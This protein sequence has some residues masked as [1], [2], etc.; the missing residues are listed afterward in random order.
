MEVIFIYNRYSAYGGFRSPQGRPQ[1]NNNI[2]RYSGTPEKRLQ[3]GMNRLGR[4]LELF[5]MQN[6]DS[7]DLSLAA[8][9]FLLYLESHDEDFLIILAVVAFSMLKK[10]EGD[11]D[12]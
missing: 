8:V 11:K 7:G 6:L 12:Q 9:L 2:Q 10:E 4:S 1:D 5:N 3:M